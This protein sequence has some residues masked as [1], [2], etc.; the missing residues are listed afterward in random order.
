MLRPVK[1]ATPELAFLVVVPL[2]TPP[3]GFD[4]MATLIDA[5][6][7][8]TRF[9]KV[10]CTE[11]VGGPATELPAMDSAGFTVKASFVAVVADAL[12]ACALAHDRHDAPCS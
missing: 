9:P 6:E 3:P 1:A 4:A 11:T 8:V 2:Q 7:V 5:V 12:R 10:S